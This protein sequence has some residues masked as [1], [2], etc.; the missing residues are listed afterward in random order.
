[1]AP[2]AFAALIAKLR[3]SL[4]GSRTEAPALSRTRAGRTALMFGSVPSYS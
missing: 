4:V 3:R 1:M 2:W